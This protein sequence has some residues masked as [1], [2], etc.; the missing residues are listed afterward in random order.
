MA[1]GVSHSY[2]ALAIQARRVV[3]FDFVGNSGASPGPTLRPMATL[4]NAAHPD[5]PNGTVL[6]DN[7]WTKMGTVSGH[8]AT[9]QP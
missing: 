4:N 6:N 1:T 8:L 5:S 3:L 2:V 7:V 9:G